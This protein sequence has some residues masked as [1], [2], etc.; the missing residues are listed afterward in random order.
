[1]FVQTIVW[2]YKRE[3]G[4][5]DPEEFQIAEDRIKTLAERGYK[6]LDALR[7]VPGRNSLGVLEEVRLAALVATVRKACA[8]LDR[9]NIADVASANSSR[10]HPSV[11]T[12]CGRANRCGKYWKTSNPKSY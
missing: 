12:A 3:N 5:I 4:G 7:R 2:T 6:L 10:A 1:M 8:D 9:I 11:K